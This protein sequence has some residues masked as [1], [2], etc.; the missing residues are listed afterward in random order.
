MLQKIKIATITTVVLIA[1]VSILLNVYLLNTIVFIGGGYTAEERG[2]LQTL[3]D[4]FQE[5]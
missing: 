2:H 1:F 3:I 4:G 5:K